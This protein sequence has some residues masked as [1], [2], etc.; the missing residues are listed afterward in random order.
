[1]QVNTPYIQCLGSITLLPCLDFLILT[2]S[3]APKMVFS[4][5]HSIA[6]KQQFPLYQAYQ[7]HGWM[8]CFFFPSQPSPPKKKN[9]N[10]DPPCQCRLYTFPR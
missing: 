6:Q 7:A 2:H 5:Q 8:R 10:T 9:T 4:R 3:F 1:M